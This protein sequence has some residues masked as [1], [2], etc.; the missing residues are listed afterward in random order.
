VKNLNTISFFQS[1]LL[2]I[3]LLVTFLN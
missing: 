3:S 2:H 1:F